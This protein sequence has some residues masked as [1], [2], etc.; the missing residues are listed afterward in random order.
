MQ[1]AL[2]EDDTAGQTGHHA[3]PTNARLDE[4]T[5]RAL[6]SSSRNLASTLSLFT[7]MAK[8]KQ[9]FKTET[10]KTVGSNRA[11]YTLPPGKKGNNPVLV[12]VECAEGGGNVP[13]N[14]ASF[15][16]LKLNFEEEM[17]KIGRVAKSAVDALR[18]LNPGELEI[19][20]GV[21]L[22][23]SAGIPL[24]TKHEG[25]ANFK[26]TLKWK[27]SSKSRADDE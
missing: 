26:V 18:K 23:G 2:V 9:F 20:F 13:R 21:E 19:E 16:D 7:L 25:K 5:G 6:R 8:P 3:L 15:T 10:K 22:G 11:V 14:A 4:G 17:A 24:I 27:N 1:A 12:L